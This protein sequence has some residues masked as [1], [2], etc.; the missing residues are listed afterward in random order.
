[1]D[2]PNSKW[3][4]T[5]AVADR[6]V[7]EGFKFEENAISFNTQCTVFLKKRDFNNILC[8]TNNIVGHKNNDKWY[9]HTSY[10]ACV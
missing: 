3:R 2:I 10:I 8:N 4:T 6:R 1:M 5:T 9:L 7:I